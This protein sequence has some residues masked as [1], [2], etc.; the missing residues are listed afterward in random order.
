MI[1]FTLNDICLH[2]R[3]MPL[4]TTTRPSATSDHWH[5]TYD[6]SSC[7]VL[8]TIMCIL[9]AHIL[10]LI[11]SILLGLRTMMCM[12][13]LIRTTVYISTMPIVSFMIVSPH[14]ALLSYSSTNNSQNYKTGSSTH[15]MASGSVQKIQNPLLIWMPK[16][17]RSGLL[18]QHQRQH[19]NQSQGL[20][21]LS[22][23]ARYLWQGDKQIM[24]CMEMVLK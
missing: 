15:S 3:P 13:S 19:Q 9:K 4:A 23:M 12:C 7:T 8:L 20:L 11:N 10:S 17:R 5:R 21:R 1:L 24:P 14:D 6:S 16:L 2:R 22:L 18:Y